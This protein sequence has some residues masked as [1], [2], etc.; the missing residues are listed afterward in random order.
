MDGVQREGVLGK[1]EGRWRDR[2]VKQESTYYKCTVKNLRII[3]NQI[4]ETD[5][6]FQWLSRCLY[7]IFSS[8]CRILSFNTSM[9]NNYW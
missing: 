2:L 9:I 8:N 7:T 1:N 5:H 6:T 3:K 4:T